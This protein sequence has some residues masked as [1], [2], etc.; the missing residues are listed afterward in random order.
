MDSVMRL[1]KRKARKYEQKHA[2]KGV[3]VPENFDK[4]AFLA[5]L[6]QRKSRGQFREK[7]LGNVPGKPGSQTIYI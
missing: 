1:G 5:D 2:I 6:R 3:A 4:E 7:L